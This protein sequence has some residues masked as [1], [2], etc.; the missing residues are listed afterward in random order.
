MKTRDKLT[1]ESK[2]DDIKS[3][4]RRHGLT[5][6][7]NLLQKEDISLK[8]GKRKRISKYESQTSSPSNNALDRKIKLLE[9]KNVMLQAEVVKRRFP[10]IR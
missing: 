2:A 8:S 1:F 4:L 9:V 3:I 5:D 10:H 7:H 6:T